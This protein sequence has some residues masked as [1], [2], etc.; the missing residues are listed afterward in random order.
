M[1]TQ[2]IIEPSDSPWSA[3]VCLVKKK[4]GTCRFCVDFRALNNVTQKDAYPLPRIDTTLENLAG[5]RW[6]CTLDLVSGYWQIKMSESSKNKT[7]FATPHRGL[8]RFNVM[9]FGL[10]N[11]PSAFQRPMEKVL[12]GL[13]PE[14]CLCYLDDIIITGADFETTLG[15]L[16]EVFQRLREANLK[17]KPK[18]CNLFQTQVTYLGHLVSKAGIECDPAKIEAIKTWPRPTNKREVRGILGIA[19]YYRKFISKFSEIASPLTKLTRKNV[20]FEWTDACE[21]AFLTLIQCL[22]NAPVLAYPRE[23]GVLIL[24]TDASQHSVAAVLS[25]EQDGEERV[26]SYGSKTLN[27]AQQQYCTTKRELLAVVTF[28]KHCKYYLLGRPFIIRTDHAPLVWLR[29]FKEPEGLY[30]RW[31]S[32]IET[33]DYELQYRPGSLHRNA[34]AISRKPARK[35]PN[36]TCSDCAPQ[37]A[38]TCSVSKFESD[39]RQSSSSKEADANICEVIPL[40]NSPISS[41]RVGAG[42]DDKMPVGETMRDHFTCSSLIS[43]VFFEPDEINPDEGAPNWLP[44][45]STE[46]LLEIQTSD[47]SI[48]FILD[49]KSKSDEKPSRNEIDDTD[50]E[51]KN[52]WFQWESLE[53]KNGL[54]Y[55]KWLDGRGS[56]VYQFL[57]P[58]QIRL[59]IFENLHANKTAGHFGRDRTVEHIRKRFY[60]P[61][62]N[63]DIARWVKSCDKCAQ[64]KPG[65]G[66]GKSPLSQFRVTAPMQSVAVDIFG[67]LP[68]TENGN[69]YVIVLGEYFSK[70]FEAWAAPDHTALTVADKIVTEFI[71]RFGCPQ[72]IHTDQGREFES[73]L[74]TLVCAKF[75]INKT[76]TAPYRPNSDGL[77]E[78]FNR[79]LKQMLRIFASENPRDWDDH[80]PFLMMAYR[81]TQQKSTGCTP[82]LL[83]MQREISCPLDLM[84][85]DPPNS[86]SDVCPIAYIEWIKS[87]MYITH[88]F[89]HKNLGLSA[90]RQKNNYDFG[91][92][93][94]AYSIG[95]WV[96]R[97]YPPTACQKLGLGWTGPYLVIK[98]ISNLTYSIQKSPDSRIINVHVDHIIP[99][100][101]NN[102]PDNW[103]ESN[104]NDHLPTENTTQNSDSIL[105]H[106]AEYQN[107][108]LLLQL[109]STPTHRVTTRSGRVIKPKQIFSPE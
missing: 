22:I 108:E 72:Q 28:L 104:N 33:F 60:W 66:L 1:L 53:V 94:R 7:S 107:P 96:W 14:K 3:P 42:S 83:F 17:L 95:D 39:D 40:A 79:T 69:E 24:D 8:F 38:I 21:N 5:S 58:S 59:L 70:W 54:L 80:L 6:F 10:T 36:T 15:N 103:L 92:K 91:L 52:L 86:V 12:F 18:K 73:E 77:V 16:A 76:R 63:S 25:Q 64:A 61:G 43:P 84:V 30:A 41:R 50:S 51:L 32:I 44:S 81:A 26:I 48:N 55:R 37:H 71:T 102:A 85:G 87:A 99:Y 68:I 9:P 13:T 105:E 57:A 89:A 67:P 23:Q 106:Q 98:K 34:D 109:M 74:F 27:P 20:P 97:W 90:K 49:C 88:E 56:T 45:W 4:D 2:K 46:Q 100:Q 93:P 19:G 78:R 65:P 11:A 47:P 31:I 82:N 75:G 62:M 29:N 35:C 101:G